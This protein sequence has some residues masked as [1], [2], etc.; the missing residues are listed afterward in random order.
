MYVIFFIII[1]IYLYI[2]WM[3]Q[4]L[5]KNGQYTKYD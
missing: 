3:N 1:F 5:T 2:I 4:L